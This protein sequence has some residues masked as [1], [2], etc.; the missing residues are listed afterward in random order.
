MSFLQKTIDATKESNKKY[1]LERAEYER[2][3]N[4]LYDIAER[5][6]KKCVLQRAN[7]GFTDATFDVI[8]DLKLDIAG[9]WSIPELLFSIIFEDTPPVV[10]RLFYLSKSPFDGFSI[11]TKAKDGG[12]ASVFVLDWAYAMLKP[13]TQP[14]P[15]VQPQSAPIVQPQPA[16]IVQPQPAP[17][18]QPH[19]APIVKPQPAPTVQPQ[20][21][22]IQMSDDDIT[23]ELNN[24]LTAIAGMRENVHQQTTPPYKPRMPIPPNA[25]M[26][27]KNP[28]VRNIFA[29][30]ASIAQPQPA[31]IAPHMSD[32][33]LARELNNLMAS[34]Y[35]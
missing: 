5:K 7:D 29:D 19:P 8:N 35:I 30:P 27:S 33:D 10:S 23:Q 14:A 17:I 21:A 31:P 16:P 13:Q 12:P 24:L 11:S 9:K 4:V 2:A 3:S 34:M 1:K 6:V 28:V 18:V 25:P 22:P 32:Y 20:P 26:K 15:I